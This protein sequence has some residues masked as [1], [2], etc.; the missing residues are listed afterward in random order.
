MTT[1]TAIRGSLYP[2]DHRDI[3]DL[4]SFILEIMA[5]SGIPEGRISKGP[6]IPITNWEGVADEY[7][8]RDANDALAPGFEKWYVW[9]NQ[10]ERLARTQTEKKWRE[11]YPVHIR[12]LASLLPDDNVADDTVFHSSRR[13]IQT[14]AED[15]LLHINKRGVRERFSQQRPDR[16]P[17]LNLALDGSATFWFGPEGEVYFYQAAVTFPLDIEF[18]YTAGRHH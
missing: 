1:A 8:R 10:F 14:K 4:L 11:N 18:Q 12:G 13:Y 2:A 3:D 9:I 5:D 15:L 6:M 17:Y 16:K 7:R